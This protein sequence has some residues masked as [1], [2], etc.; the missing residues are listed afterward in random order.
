MIHFRLIGIPLFLAALSLPAKA[1]SGRDAITTAQVAAAIKDAGLNVAAAQ[2]TLLSEVV[3]KTSA[4]A[5]RV[6]SVGPW[7]GNLAR[8]RL[9]CVISDECLPFV[10]TVRR[11]Q[12]NDSE[13]AFVPSNE[14][15]S[16]RSPFETPK[17]EVVVHIGSAAVLLLDGR[18]VHIQ[19][20]V[21][22]LENGSV[23]QTIRVAGKG[24]EQTYLAEVCSDGLLRGTL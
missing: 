12:R 3:A 8:V 17:S 5:L 19:L 24:H 16:R 23:G 6:E 14:Q 18:H 20:A 13:A 10:V 22:C 9:N 21:I 2:V 11:S 15:A 1:V 4:P 7:E